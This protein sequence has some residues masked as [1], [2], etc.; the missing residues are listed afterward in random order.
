MIT[1]ILLSA[2]LT[3]NSVFLFL[4]VRSLLRHIRIMRVLSDY[5]DD[6]GEGIE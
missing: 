5:G 2:L 3:L 6:Y 4:T 1:I